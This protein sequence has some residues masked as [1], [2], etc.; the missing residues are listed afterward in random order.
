MP[1]GARGPGLA[2]PGPAAPSWAGRGDLSEL[3]AAAPGTQSKCGRRRYLGEPGPFLPGSHPGVPRLP[4]HWPRGLQDLQRTLARDSGFRTHPNAAV[5]PT[6]A[7]RARGDP[8]GDRGERARPLTRVLQMPGFGA[9]TRTRTRTHPRLSFPPS[10]LSEGHLPGRGG[11]IQ[12]ETR[13][14]REEEGASPR[15]HRCPGSIQ[16][17]SPGGERGPGPPGHPQRNLS[18]RLARGLCVRRLGSRCERA[19]P[20]FSARGGGGRGGGGCRGVL[21]HPRAPITR[22]RGL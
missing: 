10:S 2:V 21:P 1:G 5:W 12:M 7:H 14:S 3:R 13:P 20:A 17:L 15:G 16:L 4:N 8:Q 18:L 11:L 19:G 22:S 9:R 6:I